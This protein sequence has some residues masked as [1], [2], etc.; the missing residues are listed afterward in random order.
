MSS[1]MARIGA[2]GARPAFAKVSGVISA[3]ALPSACSPSEF[4]RRRAGSMV[5]TSEPWP[6]IAARRPSAA[7]TVV[8]PTPPLPTVITTSLVSSAARMG[9][10]LMA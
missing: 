4:A 5:H 9:L 10:L 1:I 7:A 3:S 6:S 2:R 8:L